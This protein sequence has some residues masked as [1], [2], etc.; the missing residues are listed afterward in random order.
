[1][2]QQLSSLRDKVEDVSDDDENDLNHDLIHQQPRVVNVV[3]EK[4]RDD[5]LRVGIWTKLDDLQHKV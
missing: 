4:D 2:Q 5:I 1:M 3:A